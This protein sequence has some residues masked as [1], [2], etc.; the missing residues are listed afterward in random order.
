MWENNAYPGRYHNSKER[1]GGQGQ[2]VSF[3][4]TDR[5]GSM[6]L[7]WVSAKDV[8][9]IDEFG[10]LSIVDD[11]RT[12]DQ[13]G[14]LVGQVLGHG[15]LVQTG[16]VS[17]VRGGDGWL[18]VSA[19]VDQPHS[20]RVEMHDSPPSDADLDEWDDVQETPFASCGVVMHYFCDPVGPSELGAPG[21]YR[22]RVSRRPLGA[23]WPDASRFRIAVWP[24][25]GPPDAPRTLRRSLPILQESYAVY[26]DP[27]HLTRRE[28]GLLVAWAAESSTPVTL[29]W[30]ADRLLTDTESVRRVLADPAAAELFG[31]LE[32]VED[33]NAPVP[34]T[35]QIAAPITLPTMT[36]SAAPGRLA[37]RSTAA[38]AH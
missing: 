28:V 19:R 24:V 34:L 26:P 33:V 11:E 8:C 35:V 15:E 6:S 17:L 3:A 30:L 18:M 22:A 38:A 37:S 31:N 9:G 32:E 23:S 36:T 10:A 4:R 16:F 12:R 13:V 21:L 2:R 1:P 5:D 14:P 27:I 25:E 7:L 29:R 20:A